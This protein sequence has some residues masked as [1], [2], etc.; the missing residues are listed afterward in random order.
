[1]LIFL[2]WAAV[3]CS[4]SQA[5]DSYS[6]SSEYQQEWTA[7]LLHMTRTVI[8]WSHQ[9]WAMRNLR[10]LRPPQVPPA[11]SGFKLS[12]PKVK[13]MV[14]SRKRHPPTPTIVIKGH[15]VEQVSSFKLLGVTISADLS[16]RQHI[17]GIVS[18]AKCLLGFLY[19]VFGSSNRRC[20]SILYRSAVLPHL[21]YCSSVWDPPHKT[22][23]QALERV[24]TFAARLVTND[25]AGNGESL[26]ALLGWPKLS[27]RRQ[28]QKLCL[29]RRIV[30][31]GSLIPPCFFEPHP[32]PTS[33]H[34]NSSPLFRPYV[35]TLQHRHS[36]K[37]S[38]VD[39]WNGIP[40]GT[41]SSSQ[42]VRSFKAKLR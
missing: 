26:R 17:H 39:V 14:I 18:K 3:T 1:M 5:F 33:S 13:M 23:I 2:K 22:H 25:W 38:V 6:R 10:H 27:T 36:F 19:R 30:T 8:M 32:R 31:G 28:F 4:I 34:R 11:S 16:W 15:Q 41:V 42:T 12:V 40:E 35:R 7:L 24:Q 9:I 20:L 21:D 37:H 29:C